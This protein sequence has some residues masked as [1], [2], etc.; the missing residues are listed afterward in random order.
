MPPVF[1]EGSGAG[2]GREQGARERRVVGLERVTKRRKPPHNDVLR[3]ANIL[4]RDQCKGQWDHSHTWQ[5]NYFSIP[6]AMKASGTALGPGRAHDR[7]AGAPAERMTALP[8]KKQA[9]KN[10]CH[11]LRQ[12]SYYLLSRHTP[13]TSCPKKRMASGPSPSNQ[14][15]K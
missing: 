4:T 2:S 7:R 5:S 10:S 13:S 11:R 6:S 15:I 14:G 9:E 12:V 8:T 3:G 1:A